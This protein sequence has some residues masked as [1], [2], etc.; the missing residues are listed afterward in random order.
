MMERENEAA[1][2]VAFYLAKFNRT[3]LE[4]LGYSAW[5]PA[6]DAIGAQLGVN[7]HTVKHMRDQFDSM[8]DIRA[9]WYQRP[10]PLSRRRVA[11]AFNALSEQALF[12]FVQDVLTSRNFVSTTTGREV[13]HAMTG[14]MAGA[15]MTGT[16]AATREA[17]P[18]R[19]LTGRAAES[20]FLE[21]FE[22]QKT[23]FNG[24]L[25]DARQY[26]AGF[27][28]K[29]SKG[30]DQ[31]YIEVKGIADKAG[32]ILF[33]DKEWESACQKAEQYSVA[34]AFNL[35]RAPAIAYINNPKKIF[36]PKRYTA[37]AISVTWQ[38]PEAQ[39][40]RAIGS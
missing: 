27:D 28:F 17:Y 25:F 10:L 31:F 9:G 20:L 37:T 1:L 36:N 6:F 32:G 38:V 4:N 19:G 21:H 22:Q 15:S 12:S 40:A 33:T 24:D 34:I 13:L 35:S 23:P 26:G 30:L 18:Q 5:K 8:F 11:E 39:V 3:A 14:P 7:P 29:I 2:I 16:D